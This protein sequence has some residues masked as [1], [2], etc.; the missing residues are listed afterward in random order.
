MSNFI[1]TLTILEER[2]PNNL[3]SC[4]NYSWREDNQLK[5]KYY[6]GTSW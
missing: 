2:Q 3:R 4:V 6:K 5:T 1:V